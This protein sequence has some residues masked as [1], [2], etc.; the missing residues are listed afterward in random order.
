MSDDI[1]IKNCKR[2]FIENI[3][4]GSCK[5]LAHRKKAGWAW[6]MD[7]NLQLFLIS[8]DNINIED[9]KLKWTE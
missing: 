1:K 8:C 7:Y 2:L 9:I 5:L 6:V 3:A 4:C